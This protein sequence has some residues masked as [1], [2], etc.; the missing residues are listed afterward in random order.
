MA[1]PC[2]IDLEVAVF[3]VRALCRA[4]AVRTQRWRVSAGLWGLLACLGL[5]PLRLQA[6]LY[7]AGPDTTDPSIRL[8][9]SPSPSHG[10]NGYAMY[11]GVLSRQYSGRLEVSNVTEVAVAGFIP[12]IAYYLAVAARDDW[13]T[14]VSFQMKSSALFLLD[15]RNHR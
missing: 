8:R 11:Y 2:A 14:K 7:V 9:W 6:Q 3:A 1:Q 10:V 13:G 5:S 15:R 12:G 4:T